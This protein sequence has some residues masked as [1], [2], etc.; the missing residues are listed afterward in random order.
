MIKMENEITML[1]W[2]L[3]FM[4]VT[5]YIYPRNYWL[6][7]FWI[8]AIGWFGV[9]TMITLDIVDFPLICILFTIILNIF[10]IESHLHG[11]KK[12]V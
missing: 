12:R 8:I 3:I 5:I 1:I 11:G 2:L 6:S 7:G 10:L 9:N 4:I